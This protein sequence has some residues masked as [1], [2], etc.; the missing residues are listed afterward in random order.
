VSPKFLRRARQADPEPEPVERLEVRQYRYL[1]RTAPFPVL[2]TLHRE[3]L[4][5]LDP[6]VRAQ[7]LVTVQE[8][9]L[10]G[11]EL[12]VDDVERLAQLLTLA[13]V[14]TPGL[15]LSVLSEMALTR[16][17]GAVLRWPEAQER[18]AGYQDWNGEDP[19]PRD[20][21]HRLPATARV[22]KLA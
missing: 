16:L 2:E 1:L 5:S 19:D 21:V 17:A 15:V 18:L 13:E 9:L 4:S 14:R 22:T 7:V 8:R 10:A 11:G 20:S 12:S 6:L 3:A